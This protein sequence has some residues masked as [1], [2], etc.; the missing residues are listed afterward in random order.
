MLGLDHSGGLI[1]FAS[2]TKHWR[3]EIFFFLSS[4]V[5]LSISSWLVSQ[6][7][8]RA[9]S[10]GRVTRHTSAPETD[11]QRLRWQRT[12]P[13]RCQTGQRACVSC[14]TGT[15]TH[16]AAH[17]AAYCDVLTVAY[18]LKYMILFLLLQ[19]SFKL[20]KVGGK[21]SGW[22]KRTNAFDLNVAVIEWK[23]ARVFGVCGCDEASGVWSAESA[24]PHSGVQSSRTGSHHRSSGL[25]W[26]LICPSRQLTL[27]KSCP[28]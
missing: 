14:Q 11:L 9:V 20:A 15:H 16:T 26:N 19:S 10:A 8:S 2:V 25:I 3:I 21:P 7:L 4:P 1:L 17:T 28:F 27:P 12:E 22:F 18:E 13:H 6:R 5:F 24:A 23:C